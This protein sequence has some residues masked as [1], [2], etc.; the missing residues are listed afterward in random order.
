MIKLV[1]LYVLWTTLFLA[2]ATANP[3]AAGDVYSGMSDTAQ[4]TAENVI[5]TLESSGY[6]VV[7]VKRTLL[8]R[9]RITAVNGAHTREVVVTRTSG[10]IKRDKVI[11]VAR[12]KATKP[13]AVVND[14]VRTSAISE[15]VKGDDVERTS[16]FSDSDK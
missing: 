3:A 12:T 13:K 14:T 7:S 1:K 4:Q 11:K 2:I 15:T 5:D 8:R 6:K 10:M 16:S 9:L